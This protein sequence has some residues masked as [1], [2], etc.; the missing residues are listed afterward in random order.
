MSQDESQ[1]RFTIHSSTENTF[2]SA[3]AAIYM[4]LFTVVESNDGWVR[5]RKEQTK[6]QQ[7]FS[8]Y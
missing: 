6:K 7:L 3:T 4:V 8:P 2:L 1:I 5:Y